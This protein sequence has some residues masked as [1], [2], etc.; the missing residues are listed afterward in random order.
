MSRILCHC[1]N[2]FTIYPSRYLTNSELYFIISVMQTL[3]RVK[4]LETIKGLSDLDKIKLIQHVEDIS[5][6]EMAEITGVSRTHWYNVK[7]GK[8]ELSPE[9]KDRFLKKF[10]ELAPFFYPS[11]SET[12]N[13]A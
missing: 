10:P 2:I 9:M 3:E 13:I 7:N 5:E 4:I 12:A 8:N 11:T 6:S 1:Q